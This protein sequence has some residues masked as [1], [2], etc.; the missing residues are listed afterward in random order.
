MSDVDEEGV[1]STAGIEE[2]QQ[3]GRLF[4]HSACK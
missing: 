1:N 4:G 3:R 2:Y